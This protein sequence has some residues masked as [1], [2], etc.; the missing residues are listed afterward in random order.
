[1]AKKVRYNGGTQSYY[2]CS[3]PRNLV[4]GKEYE[5]IS[6]NVRDFQTDYVLKGIKG[7]F[8]SCWF[9][10]VTFSEKEA[11]DYIAVSK[12]IPVVGNQYYC[13]VIINGQSFMPVRTSAVTSVT[14]EKNNIFRVATKNHIYMVQVY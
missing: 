3:E 2:G 9:D 5:V 10:E 14:R 13:S 7:Y 11:V 1:M 8:N 6:E 12:K 4:I